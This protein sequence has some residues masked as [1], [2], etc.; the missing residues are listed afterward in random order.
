[1]DTTRISSCYGCHYQVTNHVDLLNHS[2]V[3]IEP[4]LLDTDNNN[5]T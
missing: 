2:S 5:F 1:M 4:T 3:I